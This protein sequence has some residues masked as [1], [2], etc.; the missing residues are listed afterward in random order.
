M[1]YLQV[2]NC[3]NLKA[4]MKF[5][6]L[7][8]NHSIQLTGVRLFLKFGGADFVSYAKQIL[9]LYPNNQNLLLEQAPTQLSETDEQE[10]KVFAAQF[11]SKFASSEQG[12]I[13]SIEFSAN[14]EVAN[15]DFKTD[16]YVRWSHF[17]SS[18][19]KALDQIC[20]IESG[21]TVVML[22]LFYV[23]TFKLIDN[24]PDNFMWSELINLDSNLIPSISK[25]NQ[26]ILS[27]T[28]W[29]AEKLNQ[30]G[31]NLVE[32]I[33][34]SRNDPETVQI[35]HVASTLMP[36]HLALRHHDIETLT[37]QFDRL[38]QSNKKT[39]AKVLM[40]EYQVLIK[41]NTEQI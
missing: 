12:N 39:L 6:P 4:G 16:Q 11:V 28:Q 5:R 37:L 21:P 34:I 27:M 13:N 23:D 38:H 20:Q 25:T 14:T 10:R 2:Q 15:I 1:Q 7:N 3:C 35:T 41:L 8:S 9:A 26:T 24:N 30:Q 18:L 32:R 36:A 19:C 31:Y 40:P 29:E 22:E 17:R 33:S